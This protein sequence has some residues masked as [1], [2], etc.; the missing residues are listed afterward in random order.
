MNTDDFL[1]QTPASSAPMNTDTFLDQNVPSSPSAFGSNHGLSHSSSSNDAPLSAIGGLE[2]GAAAMGMWLPNLMNQ[3]VA[4][5]QYLGRGIASGID[6]LAGIPE[7]PRGEVWQPFYSSSDALAALPSSLQPH[8]PT[9]PMGV[10]SDIM[11]QLAGNILGGKIIQ[12]AANEM[13]NNS[14]SFLANNSGEPRPQTYSEPELKAVSQ[15]KYQQYRNAGAT[16]NQNGINK[17]IGTIQQDLGNSG[18]M[19]PKLH[20]DTLS[21]VEDLKNDAAT[22][23]MDLEKLD[24][25]RQLL[26]DVV[27]KNTDRLN[28]ANPDA[29]KANVA[30]KALDNA[31][32]TLGQQHLSNG[33]P[34]AI[35]ALQQGR[36]LYAASARVRDLQRIIDNAY[37]TDNP[38]TGIKTGFR[39][40]A[41]QVNASPRGWTPEE[42]TAINRAARTG[43]L[44]GALKLGGSRIISGIAG[45]TTGFAGGGVPGAIAGAMTGEALTTPLRQAANALQ[46]MRAQNVIDLV[47][48]RPEVQAIMSQ[49]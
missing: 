4:G 42:V 2:K 23:G 46:R 33:S 29:F 21:V 12:G 13:Q 41:K 36:D 22:G 27:N 26:N 34:Q 6:K 25:Y 16:L 17:V 47:S 15:V 43:L 5:P 10:A 8:E 49:P 28:G 32:D 30:I 40:L 24:Q 45:G 19:N 3:A 39:A 1:D 31:V 48:Q 37:M 9:T 44:T 7:Q 38:V 35:E 11:G 14:N 18:L 20:G